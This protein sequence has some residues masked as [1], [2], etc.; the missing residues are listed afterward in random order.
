LQETI[1]AALGSATLFVRERPTDVPSSP[2]TRLGWIQAVSLFRGLSPSQ[3]AEI[4]AS[5]REQ[6]VPRRHNLF[7]EGDPACSMFVIGSGLVKVTQLT[8]SGKEII[9]RVQGS[10]DLVGGVE[11][12]TGRTHRSNAETIE[13]CQLLVWEASTF[14]AYW[15]RFPVMLGNVANILDERLQLLEE[16]FRDVATERVPQRVARTL[17]RLLEQS[18]GPT[19]KG[20]LHLS[21]EE[22][23]QMTGTTLFTVS[24]LLCQWV[25]WGILQPETRAVMVGNL[26][27]LINLA[28]GEKGLRY[29]NEAATDNPGTQMREVTN[30][31]DTRP[32]ETSRIIVA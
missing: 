26:P 7:R 18:G 12:L 1:P 28:K 27:A 17:L 31:G 32:T 23:A 2:H 19:C 20:P 14:E 29:P 25:E 22:L 13:P 8:E 9:L 24:R 30:V 10:G 5:G 3:C 4:A 16:C 15:A 6:T 11:L 21:C